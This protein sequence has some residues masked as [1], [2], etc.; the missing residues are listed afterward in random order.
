MLG[1]GNT[2]AID[3]LSPGVPTPAVPELKLP[4]CGVRLSRVQV[5]VRHRPEYAPEGFYSGFNFSKCQQQL[6]QKPSR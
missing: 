5:F 2:G 3:A 6:R 1:N 4:Y